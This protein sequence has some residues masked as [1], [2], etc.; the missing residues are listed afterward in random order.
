MIKFLLEFAS[1]FWFDKNF[2]KE[3]NISAPSYIFTV[4]KIPTWW[5]QYPSKAPLLTGWL[6]GPYAYKRKN[7][8]EKQFKVL[9]LKSLSSFFN[10]LPDY[11]EK[12]LINY[13]VMNWIKEPHILGGYSFSTLQTEKARAFLNQS[14]ENI[15]YFAGEYILPNSTSTV[16][17]ALISGKKVAEKILKER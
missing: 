13:K 4:E 12:K 17:A 6:A 2:L 9:L 15:F 10:M 11:F 16:D 1:A 8:S 7:Y 5:T 3:K 14:Y